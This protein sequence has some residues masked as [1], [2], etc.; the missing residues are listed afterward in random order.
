[1]FQPSLGFSELDL[2]KMMEETIK[3]DNG[4]ENVS[5]VNVNDVKATEKAF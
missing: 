2:Y 3:K 1:M 5:Y 4:V